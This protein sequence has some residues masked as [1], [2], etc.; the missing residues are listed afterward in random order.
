MIPPPQWLTDPEAQACWYRVQS[1]LLARGEWE[2]IFESGLA[3]AASQSAGYLAFAREVRA[4][5]DVDPDA[6]K[7]L[8]RGLEETHRLARECLA[9]Y[10]MI[11]H[12]RVSLTVLNAEGLDAEI[13]AL[14]A[15]F[16]HSGARPS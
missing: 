6:M 4:L 1:R 3:L 9:D 11:L 5:K 15:P 2:E 16:E 14:C 13:V 10:L 8:E 12:K 7:D